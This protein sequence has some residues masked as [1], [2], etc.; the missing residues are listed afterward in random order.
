MFKQLFKYWSNITD[1]PHNISKINL[2]LY[3]NIRV[4]K[5][6]L[7]NYIT[8]FIVGLNNLK[9]KKI[10]IYYNFYNFEFLYHKFSKFLVI[11]MVFLFFFI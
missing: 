4:F 6:K 2:F 7:Y 3:I 11:L 8:Y 9:F 10:K 5:I 1:A